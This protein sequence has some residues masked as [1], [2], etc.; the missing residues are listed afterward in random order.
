MGTLCTTGKARQAVY[1]AIKAVRE[2]GEDQWVTF[3]GHRLRLTD[4]DKWNDWGG[5]QGLVKFDGRIKLCNMV[6][7]DGIKASYAD[8]PHYRIRKIQPEECLALVAEIHDR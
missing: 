2:T 6:D 3:H 5:F 7:K 8:G 1:D 4:P